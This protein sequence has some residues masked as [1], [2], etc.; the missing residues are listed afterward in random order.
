[1]VLEETVRREQLFSHSKELHVD[2]AGYAWMKGIDYTVKGMAVLA[3][4]GAA[5]Y[6]P[7][8]LVLTLPAIGFAYMGPKISRK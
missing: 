2:N 1:M 4:V 3:A 6:A 5:Y 8:E 7:E